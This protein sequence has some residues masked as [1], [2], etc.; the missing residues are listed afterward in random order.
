MTEPV[1]DVKEEIRDEKT[2][3]QEDKAAELTKYKVSERCFSR[4]KR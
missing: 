4:R 1:K 3:H 2:P